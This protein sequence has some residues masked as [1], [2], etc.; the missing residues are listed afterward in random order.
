[1]KSTIYRYILALLIA[2]AYNLI[3]IILYQITVYP[4]YGILQLFYDFTIQEQSFIFDSVTFTFIPAC[5]AVTAY[6]VMAVLTITT[7]GLSLKKGL[8]IFAYGFM[9]IYFANL[10]R[11][12]T[13]ISIYINFGKNYFNTLH[14]IIW[15]F[16]STIFVVLV[17]IYLTNHYKVKGIPV[18]D[19]LKYLIKKI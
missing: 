2:L 5:I 6:I 3:Y 18:Y 4:A 9:A 15:N 11:I 19:D 17:W 7:R 13:L 10:I 12:I 1:M 14:F 8:T 16:L